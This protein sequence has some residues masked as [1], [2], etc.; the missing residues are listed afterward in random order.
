MI[1]EIAV[2][3]LTPTAVQQLKMDFEEKKV[4]LYCGMYLLF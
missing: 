4:K 1:R 2:R 3:T